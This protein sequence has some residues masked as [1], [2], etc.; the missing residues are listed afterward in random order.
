MDEKKETGA[1]DKKKNDWLIFELK[2]PTEYQGQPITTLDLTKLRNM[3]GGELNV[4]YDLYNNMGGTGT[5][6][7]ESTLLF[8]QVIASRVTGYPLEAI[9]KISARDSVTLKGRIYRFF[10]LSV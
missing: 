10:F 8:A 2:D 3:N 7:Q 6:M 9:N 1:K 5:I 4:V